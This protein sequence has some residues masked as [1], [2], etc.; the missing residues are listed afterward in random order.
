MA[1][2]RRQT[3]GE[4]AADERWS[5][6]PSNPANARQRDLERLDRKLMIHT[7]IAGFLGSLRELRAE[8][9]ALR[10][11]KAAPEPDREGELDRALEAID[12]EIIAA[13]RQRFERER[14]RRS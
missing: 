6:H 7:A 3:P 8:A 1:G 14:Q 13:E 9:E 10:D 12:R 4:Q 5:I 2:L 11:R